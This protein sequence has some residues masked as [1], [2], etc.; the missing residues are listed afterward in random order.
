MRL[1]TVRSHPTVCFLIII[2]MGRALKLHVV[3]EETE[4]FHI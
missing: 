1:S 3:A 4:R 2:G